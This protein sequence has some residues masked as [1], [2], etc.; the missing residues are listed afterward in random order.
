[1]SRALDWRAEELRHL[2]PLS[3]DSGRKGLSQPLPG[4]LGFRVQ[5]M[6]VGT[7]ISEQQRRG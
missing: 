7:P 4:P 1:M 5:G 6:M 3:P 2:A